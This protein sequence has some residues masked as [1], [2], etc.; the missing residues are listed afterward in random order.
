M[1]KSLLLFLAVTGLFCVHGQKMVHSNRKNIMVLVDGKQTNWGI[2]PE[3]NPDRLRVYC[4]KEKMEVIFQ[5]DID[6]AFFSVSNHDTIKFSIIL[7]SRDTANT[8]ILGIK[9]LPVN[10]NND[11]KTYWLSQIWSETKYN[12]VNIDRLTF[13]LDSLYRSYIPL[14][15]KTKNDFEYYQVLQKF[16][17]SLHDGHSQVSDNGQF[18]PYTDYIPVSLEDFNKKVY[19]TLVRKIP[20]LDS[21]WVGAELIEVESIPTVR[22]LESKVFPFISASTDRHLLMQGVFKIQSG[23]KDEPFRGKI[24]KRDGKIENIELLR[25]GEATRTEKDQYWGP[26]YSY[27]KELVEIKWLGNDIVLL[28]FNR[29]YPEDIAIKDFEKHVKDLY[30]AKGLIIDLRQ[31]GGGSTEVAWHLQKYLTKKSYFL[32]YGWE[33][34]M[35]DG[36]RKANGNWIEEDKDYFLNKAYRFVKPDTIF[37]PDTLKRIEC[38]AVILIGRYTFSA[39]EDFL[40]NIYELPGRPKLIGEETGGS[41]GS[42][43]V[44]P[45]LPGDGYARICTRRICYPVSYK[46]FVNCGVKPDIEVK[47]TI[48]DYLNKK[49]VVLDA[50]I[51]ELTRVLTPDK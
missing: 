15:L 4:S 18:F 40:V 12:F 9:D 19:I 41:T 10:I 6:T 3:T 38:P 14:V 49:D 39:A 28:S 51:R 1:K 17:A 30:K 36:V 37:I 24:Q 7:H 32:N 44:V 2:S 46:R 43:L 35:N 25:N 22:Y 34:R 27:P 8:E 33:T 26:A 11:E 5:T 29:F 23:L 42:P 45:D 47:Q 31:N 50:G 13:D 20:G 21:T 16:M 48:E